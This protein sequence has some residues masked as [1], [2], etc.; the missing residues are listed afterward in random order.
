MLLSFALP[1]DSAVVLLGRDGAPSPSDLCGSEQVIFFTTKS[2][3]FHESGAASPEFF[4][5]GLIRAY[6]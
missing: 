2:T 4:G 1:R 6:S 3:N 5:F